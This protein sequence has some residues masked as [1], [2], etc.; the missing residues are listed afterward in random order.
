MILQRVLFPMTPLVISVWM[1]ITFGATSLLTI[2]G[3]PPVN[4]LG[5]EFTGGRSC[6]HLT[7]L[8]MKTA[9][10]LMIPGC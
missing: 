6:G 10:H 1:T 5:L 4:A 7:A 3:M 9:L 8:Q 2:R